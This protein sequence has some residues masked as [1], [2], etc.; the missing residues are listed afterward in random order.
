M[1]NKIILLAFLAQ[2]CTTKASI[3]TP[4]PIKFV[5]GPGKASTGIISKFYGDIQY[6][7]ATLSWKLYEQQTNSFFFI[8]RSENGKDF[9][10]LGTVSSPD[11]INFQYKDSMALPTGFYRVKSI[12]VD[13]VYSDIIRLSSISGLPE[14]KVWPLLFDV[15][16]TVEVNSKINE[17]FNVVL[18]NSKG[19]VLSSRLVN[20]DKGTSKIVFDDGISFLYHDEYTMTVTG[21][22]YSYSKKLYKK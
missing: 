11:G 6:G 21:I 12:G 5:S 18:T 19:Q 8:E 10:E 2:S 9:A 22:Q 13:T 17:A 1:L 14:I 20:A 15:L 3:N 16:I 4:F 7:A